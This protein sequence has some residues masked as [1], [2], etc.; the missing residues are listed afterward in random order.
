MS[1]QS[2]FEYDVLSSSTILNK[3]RNP[4]YAQHLY[5]ALCNTELHR[6]GD[7]ESSAVIY[8][9]RNAAAFVAELDARTSQSIDYIFNRESADYMRWYCSGIFLDDTNLHVAEGHITSEIR[10]DLYD[11]GWSVTRFTGTSDYV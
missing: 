10:V 8:S 2:Q 1:T 9:W 11:I 6:I 7:T 5:A 4:T 3:I